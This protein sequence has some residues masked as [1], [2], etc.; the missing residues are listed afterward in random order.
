LSL[1]EA[2]KFEQK[3]TNLGR[4][5]VLNFFW[6]ELANLANLTQEVVD[7]YRKSTQEKKD[8]EAKSKIIEKAKETLTKF[9][10]TDNIIPFQL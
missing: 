4:S 7:R 6:E 9:G 8:F 2:S 5:R 10:D 1:A 3:T